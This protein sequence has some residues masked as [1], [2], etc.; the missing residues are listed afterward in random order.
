MT[1]NSLE[2]VD[3]FRITP[4]DSVLETLSPLEI[5]G[6]FQE[7]QNGSHSI[8]DRC[9]LAALNCGSDNDDVKAMMEKYRDFRVDVIRTAGGIE[10]EIR[11]APASAAETICPRSPFSPRKSGE[12]W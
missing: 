5:E 3:R 10:L 4:E 2:I 12:C 6:L 7:S 11:N 1:S 8:L 9:T